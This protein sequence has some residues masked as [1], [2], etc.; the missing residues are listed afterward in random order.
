MGNRLN[1][2]VT[3]DWFHEKRTTM[4]VNGNSKEL[5]LY[6]PPHYLA[7]G[8]W[9]PSMLD[10]VKCCPSP[11][12]WDVAAMMSVL[13]F[14]YPCGDRTLF[15]EVT[16]QPWLSEVDAGA[17]PRLAP[18]P[19]HGRCWL[20]PPQI[21]ARLEQLLTEEATR[22]CGNHTRIYVLLSGG[23]DS[24]IAAGILAKLYKAGQLP[25]KPIA[26]TWGVEGCR[27]VAYA[28]AVADILD[29]AWVRVPLAPD[30][31]LENIELTATKLGCLIPPTDLH[32]MSW[33]KNA[34]KDAIVYAGSYG[35]S[36]GRAEFNSKHLLEISPLHPFNAL[37]LIHPAVAS[38]AQE[39]VLDALSQ[40]RTRAGV[41]PR[42][43]YA[44]HE[45]QGHYMRGM[46]AHAMNIINDYCSLYQ[47]F[48]AYPV[49]SF[50]WSLHPACRDGRTYAILLDNL[51]PRLLQ[52]PWARTN[53]ALHGRTVGRQRGLHT[54]FHKYARWIQGPLF[55]EL[56][57]RVTPEWFAQT[58]IFSSEQ[59]V[60]LRDRVF[61]PKKLWDWDYAWACGR[62]VWLASF[63]R[64]A[65]IVAATKTVSPVEHEPYSADT[66]LQSTPPRV[67]FLR[68]HLRNVKTL[69]N[70]NKQL[71][72]AV[73]RQRS[74]AE[75]PPVK[76]TD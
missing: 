16:R 17:E 51:H 27:D 30:S 14:N 35:D 11:L 55:H 18:I 50:M 3:Q 34:E 52:L 60:K 7:Q 53:K 36:I 43:A 6:Q 66:K 4:F 44:E 12:T 62:L 38:Q 5:S 29:F 33:F 68:K 46:I 39:G 73:L 15:N 47:M 10:A 21:A 32:G 9:R 31:I 72:L 63:Q 71:R 54:Q 25:C 1:V 64:F 49:F 23:L 19:P 59:I 22:A 67:G 69:Y 58:G 74:I 70:I 24:R 40:L 8:V 41:C 61:A 56:A 45:M 20:E 42:H 57:D 48:T 37:G 13:C 2:K 76:T 28:K 65:E 26:V 75:F